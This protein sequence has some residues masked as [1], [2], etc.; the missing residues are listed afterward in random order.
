MA[1][2]HQ[3]RLVI[4]VVF[5]ACVFS[6]IMGLH[7]WILEVHKNLHVEVFIKR[8]GKRSEGKGEGGQEVAD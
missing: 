2:N 7:I 4:F 5:G 6:N 1:K 8:V 3:Q